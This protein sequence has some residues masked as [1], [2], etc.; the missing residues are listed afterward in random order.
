MRWEAA[1]LQHSLDKGPPTYCGP[2]E[3]LLPFGG[4]IA[5]DTEVLTRRSHRRCLAARHLSW[6]SATRFQLMVVAASTVPLPRL[7]HLS[8]QFTCPPLGADADLSGLPLGLHVLRLLSVDFQCA[9]V[10]GTGI[11]V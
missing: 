7:F 3:Q 11:D 9:V 6:S 10:R 1:H 4:L 8:E 2:N 5:G